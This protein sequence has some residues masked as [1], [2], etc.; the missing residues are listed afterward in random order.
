M[1][2]GGARSVLPIGE[3]RGRATGA[4]DQEGLPWPLTRT[5]PCQVTGQVPTLCPLGLCPPYLLDFQRPRALLQSLTE[6]GEAQGLQ[7]TLR[8]A[9]RGQVGQAG[10]QRGP[11]ALV[12]PQG[13]SPSPCTPPP[14]PPGCRVLPSQGTLCAPS[15]PYS[16]IPTTR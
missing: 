2:Y 15:L 3:G 12:Q 7:L 5:P 16:P 13:L 1:P 6:A 11:R 9:E 10:G 14:Q 4:G 8:E